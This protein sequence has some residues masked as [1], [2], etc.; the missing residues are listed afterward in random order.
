MESGSMMLLHSV[1]IGAILYA[2]MLIGLGQ[3]QSVAEYRSILI[4]ALVLVY[5][6]MFGHKLPTSV[7][8]ELF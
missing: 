2:I 5:M 1:V 6:I 7:N 8:K 4:A 3:K